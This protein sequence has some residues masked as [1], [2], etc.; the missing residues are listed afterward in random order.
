MAAANQNPEQKAR[1]R[2][3]ELLRQ[4]GWSVQPKNKINFAAGIG[5]A[6]REYQTDAGPADYVLFVARQPVGVIEAKRQQEGYRLTERLPDS[7]DR[8]SG[9]VV[10]SESS[11]LSD[12]DGDG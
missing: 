10:Q 4:A 5:V 9:E 7:G 2:I 12:P 11:P 3:D 6:V 8:R 1:D